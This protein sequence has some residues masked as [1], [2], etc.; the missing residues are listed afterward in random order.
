MSLTK[1]S[2]NFILNNL[3]KDRKKIFNAN[4]FVLTLTATSLHTTS[5]GNFNDETNI[6]TSLVIIN[7]RNNLV[8]ISHKS[9]YEIGQHQ[10]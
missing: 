8:H 6:V 2:K 1:Q 10:I 5:F 3:S 7:S 9:L 4:K